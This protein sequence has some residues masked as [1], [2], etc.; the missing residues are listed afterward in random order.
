MHPEKKL[1]ALQQ[2]KFTEL[3]TERKKGVPIAYLLGY[4]YFYGLKFKV[5]P[6]VLIPRPESEWLVG[7]VLDLCRTMAKAKILD[8]GTGSGAIAVSI[9]K[10]SK[11][12]VSASDISSKALS[13]AKINAKANKVKVNFIKSDLL[14]SVADKFDIIIANLPYVPI[15]DYKKLRENLKYEPKHALTDST[16]EFN[17]IVEFISQLPNHLNPNGI[18]LLEIDPKTIKVKIPRIFH[19]QLIKDIRGLNRFL[20]LTLK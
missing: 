1:T 16:D 5:T 20:M 8:V 2:K 18:A 7:K 9:A 6:D 17:L 10:N 13:V 4:K 3:A 19:R 12:K 14:K 15:S 11:A